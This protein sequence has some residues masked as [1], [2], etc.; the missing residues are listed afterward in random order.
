MLAKKVE[1]GI[2]TASDKV[3]CSPEAPGEVLMHHL[4]K[5]NTPLF[6]YSVCQQ[7]MEYSPIQRVYSFKCC[8]YIL[9]QSMCLQRFDIYTSCMN[10]QQTISN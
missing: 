7:N 2:F 8:S 5:M 10:D 4:Q 3:G 1:A 6:P 9:K